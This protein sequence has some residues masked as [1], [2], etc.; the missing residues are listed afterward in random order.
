MVLRPEVDP[1]Q[2]LP[3]LTDDFLLNTGL[4]LMAFTVVAN[5]L[6]AFIDPAFYATPFSVDGSLVKL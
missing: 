2:S 3:E 6:Y 4:A 5:V 1:N